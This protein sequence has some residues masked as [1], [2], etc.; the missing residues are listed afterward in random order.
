MSY[1]RRARAHTHKRTQTRAPLSLLSRFSLSSLS[2]LISIIYLQPALQSDH[3]STCVRAAD[4]RNFLLLL[5]LLIRLS[6]SLM[7]DKTQEVNDSPF[8]IHN[9]LNKPD[10]PRAHLCFSR[11]PELSFRIG[12]WCCPNTGVCVCVCVCV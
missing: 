7:E 5:L 8:S 2:L 11:G 4:W 6:V 3:F 1:D 12:P 9:L 10:K